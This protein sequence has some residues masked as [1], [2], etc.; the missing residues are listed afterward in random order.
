[1]R[2]RFGEVRPSL[3]WKGLLFIARASRLYQAAPPAQRARGIAKAV[4]EVHFPE[5][6]WTP[7]EFT[8][9]F[10]V[11]GKEG[12]SVGTHRVQLVVVFCSKPVYDS[13]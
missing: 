4:A 6:H 9:T 1:M 10:Q 5:P 2:R 11:L 13:E 3:H 12:E 8:V 7:T